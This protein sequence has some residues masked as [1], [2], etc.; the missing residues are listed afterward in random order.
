MIGILLVAALGNVDE[1]IEIVRPG[2]AMKKKRFVISMNFTEFLKLRV[3]IS[4]NLIENVRL[5][6]WV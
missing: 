1:W 2:N 6:S 4:K 3:N 5:Y